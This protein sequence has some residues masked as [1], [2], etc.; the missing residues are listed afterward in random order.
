MQS[1]KRIG[2]A[3]C[4][5]ALAL[6]AAGAMAAEDAAQAKTWVGET[7]DKCCWGGDFRARLVH[8]D[9]IPIVADPPGVTRR[10][11][12]FFTRFRTR[13]WGQWD[14]EENITVKGRVVNE[15]REFF[16]PDMDMAPDVSSYAFPDELVVDKLYVEMRNLMNDKLD[17]KVGRQDLIYGTGKVILEGTPK[18]GSRTIY[19]DAVKATWKGFENTTVDLFGI[20]NES[21]N[22][23]GI[24]DFDGDPD[25]RDVTGYTGTFNDNVESGG[26]VYVKSKCPMTA[27]PVEAYYIYKD[28]SDWTAFDSVAL[29]NVNVPGREVHTVGARLM[30]KLSDTVGAALEVAYQMGETDD[31]RDTD[32]MMV[33]AVVN[34]QLPCE[35]CKPTLSAG[36]YYLSGDDPNTTDDEGWN[37]L[38]ARWPQYSEL[39]VYAYDA[40]SAGRWSNLIMPHVDLSM[41]V[42]KNVKATALI[43]LMEAVEDDGPGTGKTRGILGTLR[44]D[45]DLGEKLLTEHDKLFG[46]V[47]VEVLDPDDYYNVDDT[48]HFARLELSYAF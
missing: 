38:W 4:A 15:W 13:L 23:L 8:F 16:E 10:G 31:N 25:K 39:Y 6:A 18:D 42:C 17:L 5:A 30:P 22:K 24:N 12:N 11:E 48:A 44:F 20:Y 3:V 29:V 46:H 45:F 37:P 1:H 40:E 34:M 33:D 2:F 19:F 7:L 43:G 36:V 14:P 9:D 35:T 21:E 41:A 26:G 47:I 32:G 28:E 27:M